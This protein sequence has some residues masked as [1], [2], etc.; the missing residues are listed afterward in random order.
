MSN[1]DY[2]IFEPSSF[3]GDI[4]SAEFHSIYH[5]SFQDEFSLLLWPTICLYWHQLMSKMYIKQLRNIFLLPFSSHLHWCQKIHNFWAVLEKVSLLPTFCELCISVFLWYF[6]LNTIIFW[7]NRSRWP[8]FWLFC[9]VEKKSK[10]Y[11]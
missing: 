4:C 11:N 3:V 8:T 5:F 9:R 10:N 6:L 7:P 1:L 2:D